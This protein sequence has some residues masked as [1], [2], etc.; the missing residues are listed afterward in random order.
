V[1][2]RKREWVP[3]IVTAGLDTVGVRMPAHPV[4][5]ALVRAVGEAI[6]APSANKFGMVSPTSAAA[7]HEQFGDAVPV[8]DGGPCVVGVESTVVAVG[9]ANEVEVLRP[10]AVTAEMLVAAGFEVRRGVAVHEQPSAPG[11]LRSHYSPGKRV[12]LLGAEAP[13]FGA[14]E[15]SEQPTTGLLAFHAVKPGYGVVEVL[16]TD[17]SLTTAAANLFGALRRLGASRV[18]EIHAEPVP[19]EGIGRAIMDRLRRAAEA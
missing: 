15:V 1:V 2:V 4:A 3:G 9:D 5:L 11:M 19:E 6:A 12:V 8:V 10:G 13:G 16:A 17:G 18:K 7:V 14:A